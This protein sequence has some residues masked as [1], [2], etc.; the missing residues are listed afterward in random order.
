MS[1]AAQVL[2]AADIKVGHTYRGKR[3][4]GF[5]GYSN[6]RIVIAMNLG[7]VQY[8]SDTVSNGRY[9]PTVSL[10]VFLRWAKTDVT[11]S[12]DVSP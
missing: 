11:E 2:Q 7:S 3:Y 1:K 9:Y 6:D 10:A 5:L 4:K 12:P 8:D